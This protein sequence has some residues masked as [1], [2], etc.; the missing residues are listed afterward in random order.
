MTD[1]KSLAEKILETKPVKAWEALH[2][3]AGLIISFVSFII[4]I[5]YVLTKPNPII[6]PVMVTI[7]AVLFTIAVCGALG[8]GLLSVLLTRRIIM[9]KKG[10]LIWFDWILG[11]P[12]GVFVAMQMFYYKSLGFF[13]LL[14][15]PFGAGAFF[16]I[17]ILPGFL[18]L[19]N[20]FFSREE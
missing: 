3:L 14:I 11:V 7:G 6:G 16:I 8:I 10:G 18:K 5:W 4:G 15:A 12:I 2:K 17:A 13:T 19:G 9:R 1:E 20:K